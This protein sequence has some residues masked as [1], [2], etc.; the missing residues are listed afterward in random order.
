MKGTW[1]KLLG[2][3]LGLVLTVQ[4]W[5]QE[6]FYVYRTDGS[7]Q[8]FELA[9]V[10]S[11]FCSRT[12]LSGREQASYVTQEIWTSDSVYRI[13]MAEVDSV[14]F[15][16]NRL[17]VSGDYK[18]LDGYTYHIDAADTGSGQFTVAFSGEVPEFQA[19]DVVVLQ[20]DTAT[21]LRRVKDAATAGGYVSLSTEA[22]YLSDLFTSGS[23]VLSTEPSPVAM[24][25]SSSGDM[26]YYPIAVGYYDESGQY[27][28]VHRKPST[29]AE[30]EKRVFSDVID[31]SG[32]SF[33]KT[34]YTNLYLESCRFDF[35]LDLVM[36]F[37][38][39]SLAEG[40]E[41][42]HKGNLALYKAVLRGNA[43]TDF[44]L[45]FDAEY[46]KN[47]DL[48]EILLKRNIHQ[49]IS[50][51]FAPSGIPINLTL[52]THLLA[53]GE[54]SCEGNFSAY[55]GFASS[56]TAELGFS[57]TQS[58]GLKPYATFN[59]DFTWHKPTIEGEAHLSEKQS[60]FPRFNFSL[61]GLVGPSF[62]IKPYLRQTLDLSFWDE[63]GSNPK[64]YYGSEY[65]MYTGFDGAAGVNF[66]PLI[67]NNILA[68]PVEWNINEALLYTSP[69]DISFK[70][71]SSETVMGD[72]PVEVTFSVR[73]Y[74]YLSKRP[75]SSTFP[76]SVK[77][78]TNCGRVEHDFANVDVSTGDVSMTW[79][80][81]A[82]P[83]GETP[84]LRATL[85]GSEGKVLAEDRWETTIPSV[86]T[87]EAGSVTEESAVLSGEVSGISGSS[88]D[89]R[90]GFFY[91]TSSVPSVGG[92]EIRVGSNGDGRYTYSL[93]GLKDNTTY[94]YCAYLSVGGQ[95]TYGDVRSFTTEKKKDEITPGQIVD[96]GLSVKWAGWNV[97]A[98]RPEEYG[99]YYAWGELHEKSDYDR[100]TYQYYDQE[101]YEWIFIGDNISCTQYDVARAQWGGSWRMPTI[102]ECQ[103]LIDKCT[104]TRTTYN[105]V[106]GQKVTG[107]NGNSIFLPAAGYRGS[108]SVYYQGLHGYYWSGTL[109][110]GYSYNA[111]SLLFS[112]GNAYW[113]SGYR[114]N[115]QSVRPV[116]E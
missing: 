15:D 19:G 69:Y 104:W 73:D 76:L 51:W 12:D 78:E 57:W 58:S 21:F 35:N 77:F 110:E 56:T 22:A 64:D 54:Y 11:M 49:P 103:E 13:P 29:R 36:S 116:S 98:S 32:K 9:E 18:A 95:Y 63:L 46:E 44:M 41:Q 97:G 55:A 1:F 108:T 39:N 60:V 5:G 115:G 87:L 72:Q 90:Y 7:V 85:Y 81:S 101:N 105:G 66:L 91:G 107:P 25:R 10:D 114:S 106:K 113:D 109:D 33:H 2:L 75:V 40:W 20:S 88:S 82:I 59:H 3:M 79:T 89:Y 14:V 70:E 65:N 71:S 93:S 28:V 102:A 26:V 17:Q 45:R 61:Y 4:A 6:V 80:P 52:N 86:R 23:F 53:D 112:L 84:Y 47:E 16:V 74:N 83:E 111:Y 31:Y 34:D 50:V 38:F 8:V 67:G 24:K 96:L 30:F 27:H 68:G 94:Y 42:Y 37:N 48:D 92:R 62:D 43:E 99:G 100:D